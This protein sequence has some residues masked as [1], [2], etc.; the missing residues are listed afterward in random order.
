MERENKRGYLKPM[1]EKRR[2][3]R[4]RMTSN[5]SRSFLEDDL[6]ICAGL[7]VV[8][9]AAFLRGNDGVLLYDIAGGLAVAWV[10]ALTTT[11]RSSWPIWL[12][13]VAAIWVAYS[14]LSLR[15]LGLVSWHPLNAADYIELVCGL[16]ACLS[17]MLKADRHDQCMGL[18]TSLPMSRVTRRGS[19]LSLV[20]SAERPR[21]KWASF[22][23]VDR[24][25]TAATKPGRPLLRLV[26]TKGALDRPIAAGTELR[27][28]KR[29]G[30][31]D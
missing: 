6:A 18:Q 12:L 24:P 25:A 7:G 3:M 13:V 1:R 14:P 30:A 23:N 27:S 29:V 17:A 15:L 9:V 10:A 2:V 28:L 31:R 11:V 21:R 16:A 19:C 20:Y 8:A 5:R 4:M 22:A 26:P